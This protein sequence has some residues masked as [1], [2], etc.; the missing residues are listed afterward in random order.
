MVRTAASLRV[1]SAVVAL[2]GMPAAPGADRITDPAPIAPVV[3]ATAAP[4]PTLVDRLSVAADVEQTWANGTWSG[5]GVAACVQVGALCVGG[6]ARYAT[7]SIT[8][9]LTGAERS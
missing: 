7:Q 5:I 9:G 1:A 2:A 4:R 3:H 8:S 6:R